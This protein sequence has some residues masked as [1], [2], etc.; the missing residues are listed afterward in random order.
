[1]GLGF[2]WIAFCKSL[3]VIALAGGGRIGFLICTISQLW[4]VRVEMSVI[5]GFEITLESVALAE[6]VRV[7]M[8]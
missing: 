4:N 5:S 8:S 3:G 6:T 1:M 2:V 7:R